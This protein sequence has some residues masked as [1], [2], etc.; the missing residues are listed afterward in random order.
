MKKFILMTSAMVV[1]G[2]GAAY[3]DNN[4]GGVQ[5]NNQGSGSEAY[6][7]QYGQHSQG[8]INQNY[9]SDNDASVYQNV[10]VD[11]SYAK[12]NQGGGSHNN[13]GINQ[14]SV[15]GLGDHNTALI[16]QDG[17]TSSSNA[18]ITQSDSHDYASISQHNSYG[19]SASISQHTGN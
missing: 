2:F 7:T 6:V 12:I 3:A 17:S 1:L 8:Y 11:Y 13:A 19:A 10:N 9:G 5:Q 16:T 4:T 15:G 14:S 18:Y